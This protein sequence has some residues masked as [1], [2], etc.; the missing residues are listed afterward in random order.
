[1]IDNYGRTIEYLRLSVTDL[2]NFRCIYCMPEDGV[3]KRT[4]SE[5]LSI[6]E[7][8]GIAA[9][10]I[11]LGVRKIR[12][13]GGEPLARRGI[14]TLCRNI[15]LIDPAVELSMTTNGSLLTAMAADLREAGVDRLNISLDT[16]DEDRF[17]LITRV[18][19][20]QDVKNGLNAANQAG[21]VNTKI[22]VVL[23][24]GI[25]D[26]EAVDFINLTRAHDVGV[27]FIE[28][29]PIGEV[30][31][32]PKER[33]ISA[34]LIENLLSDA[35]LERYDGVSRI[36]HLPDAKGTVGLITPMSRSFCHRCNRIRVTADGKLKPCLHSGFEIDLKGLHGEDLLTAMREGILNKPERHALG[37]YRSGS[38]RYM[39]EIGG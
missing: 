21:F 5:M 17:Q 16:L 30:A 20:L 33:F 22:N 34:R 19:S 37:E 25:N 2:C 6:E 29:M 15:K 10:A 1:M 11:S 32:W 13:T 23:L 31:Q 14:L 7:L 39:N 28:L 38:R 9:A 12:L 4:H 18:G 3:Q 26:D 24:G 8:T 27:R 35:D 36:Y